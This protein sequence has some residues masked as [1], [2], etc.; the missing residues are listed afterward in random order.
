MTL[1]T[2]GYQDLAG[3]KAQIADFYS[4]VRQSV[5][6]NDETWSNWCE[7]RHSLLSIHPS[8]AF[9][10]AGMS[11][12]PFWNYD[13]QW[14]TSGRIVESDVEDLT[15][16]DDQDVTRSFIGVGNIEFKLKEKLCRLPIYWADSYGGGWLLPFR[17][18]TN[19]S[20]TYGSGRYLLDGAKGA[21]L[22]TT[23]S[24]ELVVDF[25]YSFHPSC[26]WGTWL[27]PLPDSKATLPMEVTAGESKHE[28]NE[29]RH[30]YR[31]ERFNC[32]AFVVD[33]ELHDCC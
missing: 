3:Y 10:A 24:D 18:D 11:P 32:N 2:S 7:A 4:I 27:C 1:S 9:V 31:C 15:V 26:V 30:G 21:D 5:L 28:K 13:P 16:S 23:D 14:R 29:E 19:G 25:N 6:P 17:D 22:G 20:L 12:A 8:S 33:G